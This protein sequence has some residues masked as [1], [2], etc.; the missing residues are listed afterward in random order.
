[1][2]GSQ[3]SRILRQIILNRRQN[4]SVLMKNKQILGYHIQ[5]LHIQHTT[6]GSQKFNTLQVEW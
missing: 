3:K 5:I 2:I 1:M 6:V 4:L